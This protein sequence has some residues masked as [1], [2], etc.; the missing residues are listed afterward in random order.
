MEGDKKLSA[1]PLALALSLVLSATLGISLAACSG[2]SAS[3][4]AE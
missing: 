2:S 4:T 3:T 1:R